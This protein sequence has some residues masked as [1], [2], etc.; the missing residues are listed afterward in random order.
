MS[1]ELKGVKQWVQGAARSLNGADMSFDLTFMAK[2]QQHPGPPVGRVPV[3]YLQPLAVDTC[4]ESWYDGVHLLTLH[5]SFVP[6]GV[7][8]Q[9]VQHPTE[10]TWRRT[11]KFC[12]GKS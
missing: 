4:G 3:A 1:C 12:N 5:R 9:L 2:A 8:S 7:S 11:E 6:K 10:I